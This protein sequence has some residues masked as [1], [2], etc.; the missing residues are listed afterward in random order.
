MS[1][2]EGKCFRLQF[3]E[4]LWLQALKC[5]EVLSLL[6]R[7]FLRNMVEDALEAF[8]QFWLQYHVPPGSRVAYAGVQQTAVGPRPPL[9]DVYGALLN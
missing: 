4:S 3:H 9:S 5:V 7:Q 1:T 2:A 6:M 8:V